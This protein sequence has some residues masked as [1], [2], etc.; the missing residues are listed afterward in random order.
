[1]IKFAK[2]GASLGETRV[3]LRLVGAF[4][5]IDEVIRLH[6][7]RRDEREPLWLY[8]LRFIQA[9]SML[10]YY[11]C[12]N[13]YW[14][15]TRNIIKLSENTQNILSV[16][17]CRSWLLYIILDLIADIRNWNSNFFFSFHFHFLFLF[18]I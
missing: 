5:S 2:L 15:A 6:T 17:S 7:T 3:I 10:G 16:W 9:Y 12:E 14:L 11:P 13:I 18:W 8:Y 4:A 1:M